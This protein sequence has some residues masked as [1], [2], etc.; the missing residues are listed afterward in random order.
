[1]H[2][3]VLYLAAVDME[4]KHRRPQRDRLQYGRPGAKAL[5]DPAPVS[6]LARVTGILRRSV[7]RTAGT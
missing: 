5:R 6:R 2:P 3:F 7:Q 4:K 1:M